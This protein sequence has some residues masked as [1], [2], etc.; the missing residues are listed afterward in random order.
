[1]KNLKIFTDNID[2]KAIEQIDLLLEQ[3]AFK[4]SKIRIILDKKSMVYF[5]TCTILYIC[6]L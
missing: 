6:M 3:D 5:I 2:E 4:E 1:M